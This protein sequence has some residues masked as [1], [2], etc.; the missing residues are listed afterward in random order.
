MPTFYSHPH[1]GGMDR[2]IGVRCSMGH[3]DG[4]SA[5]R[6]PYGGLFYGEI[7]GALSG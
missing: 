7:E 1:T 4:Q 6:Y 5:L 3:S 2:L